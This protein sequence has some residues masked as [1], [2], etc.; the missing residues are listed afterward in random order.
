MLP[1][2]LPRD[3]VGVLHLVVHLDLKLQHFEFLL[4]VSL[5]PHPGN[6]LLK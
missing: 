3:L 4:L 1:I 2:L 6:S 5:G